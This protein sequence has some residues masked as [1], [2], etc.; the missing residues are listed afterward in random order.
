MSPDW[1]FVHVIMDFSYANAYPIDYFYIC[2]Q[3][4][5]YLLNEEAVKGT[6]NQSIN[7]YTYLELYTTV[8]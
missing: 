1:S 2:V 5:K 3:I 6:H 7:Q 8:N 4:P